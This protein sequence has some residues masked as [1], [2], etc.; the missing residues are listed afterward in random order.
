VRIRETL[1]WESRSG[2]IFLSYKTITL[3]AIL[4]LAAIS[5]LQCPIERCDYQQEGYEAQNR[6]L[7]TV[8]VECADRDRGETHQCEDLQPRRERKADRQQSGARLAN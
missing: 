7:E 4:K 5:S 2:W 8:H 3:E 6:I 1:N